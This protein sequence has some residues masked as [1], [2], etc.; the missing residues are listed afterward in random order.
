VLVAGV[1]AASAAHA[2]SF[3]GFALNFANGAQAKVRLKGYRPTAAAVDA[4]LVCTK[5]RSICNGKSGKIHA[6]VRTVPGTT[7]SALYGTLRYGTRLSCGV[8][9]QVDGT[10]AAPN[11]LFCQFNCPSN[12]AAV[13]VSFTV[14]PT[15]CS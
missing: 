8:Y 12:A 11:M 14:G 3:C 10:V 7:E 2:A 4:R 9:C 5:W 15:V 1:T 13:Q 6:D